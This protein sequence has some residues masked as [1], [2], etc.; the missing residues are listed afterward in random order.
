LPEAW[1][2]GNYL[3]L[4]GN[5]ALDYPGFLHGGRNP[6]HLNMY[7]LY[8]FG[9]TWNATMGTPLSGF[10]RCWPTPERLSFLFSAITHWLIHRNLWLLGAE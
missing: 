2:E 10:Y 6:Y 4:Q 3:I 9:P 7:G 8:A 5:C 1:G